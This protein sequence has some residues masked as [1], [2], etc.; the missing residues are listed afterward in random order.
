M[1]RSYIRDR[2]DAALRERR[3]D[4][5]SPI[6]YIELG[7]AKKKGVAKCLFCGGEIKFYAF[8]CPEGGAVACGPCKKELGRC[9]KV[10][11]VDGGKENGFEVEDED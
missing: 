3:D 5:T 10:N 4:D 6:K 7:W 8:L 11:I 2:I 1:A 9:G